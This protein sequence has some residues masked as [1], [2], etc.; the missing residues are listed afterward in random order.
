MRLSTH[1]IEQQENDTVRTHTCTQQ[2]QTTC[3]ESGTHNVAHKHHD[4]TKA[5][6]ASYV[7]HGLHTAC[8]TAGFDSG[9]VSHVCECVSVLCCVALLFCGSARC[10]SSIV[11]AWLSA[12]CAAR[13]HIAHVGGRDGAAQRR[14]SGRFQ[15]QTGAYRT[16]VAE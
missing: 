6:V 1:I 10:W 15:C 13:D 5:Q 3:D 14:Q 8:I 4:N 12:R 16:S 7:F 2:L 11:A 9:Y